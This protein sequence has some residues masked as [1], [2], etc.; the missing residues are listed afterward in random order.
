MMRKRN[1][2]FVLAAALC[3]L[4]GCGDQSDCVPANAADLPGVGVDSQASTCPPWQC[5]TNSAEINDLPI[6]E[7]H[8]YPG[9]NTGLV[10]AWNAQ[11]VDFRTM[12]GNDYVIRF[13]EGN[14]Y[15]SNGQETLTGDDLVG[16][17]L[18]IRD[19]TTDTDIEVQIHKY[20]QVPSWTTEPF[21]VDRYIFATYNEEL[22]FF[23]PACTDADESLGESAWAVLIGGER[24]SWED[25]TVAASG[26]DARGWFNIACYGNSLYKMKLMGYDPVP[27]RENPHQTVPEQRQAAL[28]MLTA[29]YCGTGTSFTET[30][31][32]L[33]WRNSA[34]WSENSVPPEVSLE[35]YWTADGALCLDTPRLGSDTLQEVMDECATVGK[36]LPGCADLTEMYGW[37]SWNPEICQ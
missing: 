26:E 19:T 23:T 35:A 2:L 14:L 5:G 11:L 6:G 15:A 27:D 18:V 28:K 37:E 29:D 10:N 1:S 16:T 20:E 24:Y 12:R 36:T 9:Q 8:A 25:K 33:Y 3:V 7:L 17:A 30:G 31:T 34:G 13:D 32:P 22:G 4:A 21:M